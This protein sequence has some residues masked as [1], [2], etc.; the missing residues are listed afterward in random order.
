MKRILY[1]IAPLLGVIVFAVAL[2]VLHHELKGLHYRDVVEK[3]KAIST[4]RLLLA[5][6]ITALSYW[7]LTGYD[8]LALRYIQHPL[9]YGRIAL[10]SFI[11]YAFSHNIGLGL[12]SGGSVRY[13]LYS[14]WGLSAIDITKVVVFCGLTFW[15]GF[16]TLAGVSFIW[17]HKPLAI[18]EV[19][20]LPF[21]SVRPLGMIVLGLVVA[22]VLL[23]TLRRT[24]VGIRD[25]KI[26]L[27]SPGLLV[28]QVAISCVDWAVAGAVLYV[29]IP[30]ELGLSYIAFL[31]IF[32]LA[33]ILGLGSQVPGG[34]G[35]F[36]TI[37]L[38]FLSPT[39]E[40]IS[41]IFGSLLVFR[42]IYYLLPL[43]VGATLLGAHEVFLRR[44]GVKRFARIFGQWVPGLVPNVL[45][46]TTFLG[47]AILLFSGATPAVS[48]RLAWLKDLLPLPII[49]ISHSLGSLVGVG[50]LLLAWG[51]RIRL[52]AAYVLTAILLAAGVV[53]SLLKGF[54]YEEAVILAVML[55]ALL[56]CRKYFYRKARLFSERFT[57]PWIA[58]VLLVVVASIWLGLFSHRYL[59]YSGDLWWRFTLVGDETA[60][61][62]RASMG[63]T[64]ALLV[65]AILRLLRPARP[66]PV[67]PSAGE[68]ERAR[69]IVESQPR[70]MG[71]LALLGDK[72][73]LFNEAGTAFIMYSLGGRSW[74]A[75]GDPVGPEEEWAEL[76]WRYREMCDRHGGWTVFYGV[77]PEDL[78]IYLDLGL[79][80]LKIGEEARVPLG[81][82]S[83]EGRARKNLRQTHTRVESEG[84]TFEIVPPEGVPQL[85]PEFKRVSDIWLESKHTREKRFSLGFFNEDY[86]KRFPAAVVRKNGQIVAFANILPG[87]GKKELSLDLM[88]YTP[89]IRFGVMEYLFASLMLWGKQEGYQWFN[90]GIA[91]LSGLERRTL[92]PLW[93][94]LG[95]FVFQ[96][97]EHFYNFQGLRA[98]KD[99]FD[100]EWSPKYLASPG[101]LALPRIVANLASLTSGGLKGVVTK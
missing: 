5:L 4:N 64:V 25:W 6:L 50:L 51:L 45:A 31:R 69:T 26:Q 99:K 89:E 78:P 72:T 38:L 9:I 30:P 93:S 13:R 1:G 71:Y 65:F 60:R 18:P 8:T 68:L 35:V 85:L 86:L 20:H 32:L 3:L 55:G 81:T 43:T 15:L 19:F 49:E 10:V 52:D 70:V 82:F 23:C 29:L 48:W 42:G 24:P 40:A 16:C 67:A 87:A 21:S 41:S 62:L 22:W 2:V 46:I 61:F 76:S 14:A 57:F 80:L 96:H 58:A 101:G 44:E 63:V 97:G 98:Y 56:P 54:D 95:A 11:A 90:L 75:L 27:P 59:E 53:F 34:L 88:R 47:G 37:V 100:P 94:R 84:C 74:I 28:A 66:E 91:P 36:E 39:P 33:Q 77:G 83:L 73:F 79:T 17:A 7:I 12:L 92:A